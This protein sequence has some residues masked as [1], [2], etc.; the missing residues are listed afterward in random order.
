MLSVLWGSPFCR[1]HTHTHAHV[2]RRETRRWGL[3]RDSSRQAGKPTKVVRYNQEGGRSR[4][5]GAAVTRGSSA[6]QST[7]AAAMAAERMKFRR[8]LIKIANR[9]TNQ[10]FEYLKFVCD[11]SVPVARMERVRSALDLFQALEERGKMAL[12]DLGYLSN[13]L[14]SVNRANLLDELTNEGIDVPVPEGTG[15]RPDFLF[16]VCLLRIAQ[17]LSSEDVNSLRFLWSDAY[18]GISADKVYSA[19][20]LFQLLERRRFL[21]CDDPR[22]LYDELHEIGRSDLCH[23]INNYLRM[24]K[25]PAYDVAISDERPCGPG[26]AGQRGRMLVP[27]FG[28]SAPW[29]HSSRQYDNVGRWGGVGVIAVEWH[30]QDGFIWLFRPLGT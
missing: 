6:K 19:T 21:T 3:D 12:Y 11:D 8:C 26:E 7:A 5:L 17:G 16:R 20:Q 13:I 28:C 4:Q 29:E 1:V 14:G 9:L 18:L 15:A 27:V 2:E 22:K 24:L 30:C 10:D 25:R 23:H